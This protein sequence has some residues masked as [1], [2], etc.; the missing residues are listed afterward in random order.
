MV[1]S[2]IFEDYQF[3]TENGQNGIDFIVA[4]LL[5]YLDTSV[6]VTPIF[7]ECE[8]ATGITPKYIQVRC[9]NADGTIIHSQDHYYTK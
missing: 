5:G 7:E 1:F 8:K 2:Y 9:L 3:I 4:D 6:D